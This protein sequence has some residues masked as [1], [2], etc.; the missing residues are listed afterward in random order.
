MRSPRLYRVEGIILKRVDFGEADRVVTV[1]TREHGKLS[2]VAKGIRRTTSRLAGHLELLTHTQLQLARG[3]NLDV[4][5]QSV[6]LHPYPRMREDLWRTTYA[7]ATAELVDRLTAEQITNQPLFDLLQV[8]LERLDSG[9]DPELASRL[10]EVLAL[11][12]LG[13]RPQLHECVNCRVALGPTGNFFSAPTGG[14]LCFSCGRAD[15]TARGLTT[16]AFKVLRLLQA[17]DFALLTRVRLPDQ[18]RRE[19]ES[20]TR[21]YLAFI[22]ERELKSSGV[23]AH[24]RQTLSA[25]SDDGPVTTPRRLAGG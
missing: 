22:L 6:T 24:L 14:V 8:T 9:Q 1:Y 13:Y 20:I 15:V 5:T 11:D 3:R 17:D 25:E 23:L 7:F 12:Y 21:G 18:L 2:T 4:I 19:I 16:N 10:F